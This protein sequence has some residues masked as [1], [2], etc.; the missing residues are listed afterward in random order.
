MHP[1]NLGIIGGGLLYFIIPTD[2]IPDFIP[3]MGFID[4]IAVLTTIINALQ[5]ELVKYGNWKK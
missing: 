3:L 2:L 5:G 1:V 4:D